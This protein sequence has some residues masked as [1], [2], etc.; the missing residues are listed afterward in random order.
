MNLPESE[1]RTIKQRERE[2]KSESKCRIQS[3]LLFLPLSFCFLIHSF[4]REPCRDFFTRGCLHFPPTWFWLVARQRC[5]LG[6]FFKVRG[7]D[8]RSI[9]CRKESALNSAFVL[10]RLLRLLFD[11]GLTRAEGER[12]ESGRDTTTTQQK[13]VYVSLLPTPFFITFS[14][15]SGFYSGAKE[16]GLNGAAI[17]PSACVVAGSIW[18]ELSLP[19]ARCHF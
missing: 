7:I 1:S 16:S 4:L 14:P 19:A 6:R 8:C 5:L 15:S 3:P 17:R 9:L 12:R 13:I 10:P 2:R 18:Q 11:C